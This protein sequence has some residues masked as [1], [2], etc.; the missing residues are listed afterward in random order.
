MGDDTSDLYADD[1]RREVLATLAAARELASDDM[2]GALADRFIASY[3]PQRIT[4]RERRRAIWYHNANNVALAFMTM[5]VCLA[6][7][8]PGAVWVSHDSSIWWA[9]IMVPFVM[10]L[11]LGLRRDTRRLYQLNE[12]FRKQVAAPPP[13]TDARAL[14]SGVMLRTSILIP[15]IDDDVRAAARA[16]AENYRKWAASEN[17]RRASTPNASTAHGPYHVAPPRRRGW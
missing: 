2:D 4:A 11:A 5:A 17:E 13:K 8:I 6:L 1:I 9:L 7:A 10:L 3:Q 16:F 14:D 15:P 12:D